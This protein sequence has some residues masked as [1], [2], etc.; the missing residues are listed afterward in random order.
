MV[1]AEKARKEKRR[2]SIPRTRM[3]QGYTVNREETLT[4]EAKRTKLKESSAG[5]RDQ[6]AKRCRMDSISEINQGN[7]RGSSKYRDNQQ[8]ETKTEERGG[9]QEKRR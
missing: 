3:E 7:R 8:T 4:K 9:S 2:E 1:P 5:K 6:D